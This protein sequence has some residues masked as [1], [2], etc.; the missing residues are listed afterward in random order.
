MTRELILPTLE[1]PRGLVT[2]DLINERGRVVQ[3]EEAEN[4]I[5]LQSQQVAKWWQRFMWGMFNPVE[6]NDSLG[7]APSQMPWFP[8]QHIAAWT[9]ASAEVPATE[10]A[11]RGD[12]IAW[13]SRHPIASPS[14]KRG[15]VDTALS[16]FKDAY[17]KWVFNWTT[18]QGNGTFQSVGWTRIDEP[19]GAPALGGNPGSN[20]I[21][22][23][24]AGTAG[25]A[26]YPTGT[27][28]WDPVTSLWNTVEHISGGTYRIVSVPAAGGA[29][30][31]LCTLPAAAWGNPFPLCGIA[32]IGTDWIVAGGISPGNTTGYLRRYNSSGAQVWAAS[33]SVTHSPFWD[34]T[35]D[36]SGNPWTVAN[37]G[38]MRKH[39]PADGT[40][41]ST[42]TPAA[43]LGN[44]LYGI[45]YDPADGNF[46]VLSRALI[47]VASDGT[48]VASTI[49]SFSNS[50]GSTGVTSQAPFAGS[51]NVPASSPH[52]AFY[53]TAWDS[54]VRT[55]SIIYRGNSP[56][57]NYGCL[58]MKDTALFMGG[59]RGV[60]TGASLISPAEAA[61]SLGSRSRLASPVTKTASQ[62][63]KITYQLDFS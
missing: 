18:A 37:D 29:T 33:L 2:V 52:E 7:R 55:G 48:Q 57:P 35:I 36:G 38:K 54:T 27:L 15:N 63:M 50:P 62:A 53:L 1:L 11:V 41:T 31:T 45:A 5:S 39:N 46:W 23:T 32:K 21:L 49:G 10:T 34:V 61:G 40:V 13:A 24:N 42:V 22:V 14:G 60:P 58:T 28:Y 19:T 6:V 25:P 47:K 30:T 17:S 44:S 26:G 59:S 56:T 51:Y 43:A 16:E 20:V 3:R 9:D 4:F 8:A 12:V